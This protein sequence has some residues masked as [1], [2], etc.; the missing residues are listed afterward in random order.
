MTS[1]VLV[2]GAS[3][4][5][6][7]QLV[8]ALLRRGT[9][10]LAAT[11]GT[12][13]PARLQGLDGPLEVAQW[14]PRAPAALLARGA[15][16]V[17]HAAACYGRAGEAPTELVEANVLAGLRL[18]QAAPAAGIRAFLHIGT[19]LPPVVSAYARSKRQFAEW[20]AGLASALPVVELR[21]EHFF[22]GGDDPSKFTTH[23][24]R[25]C[26]AHQPRLALTAGTQLRD[27]IHVDD[28]VSAILAVLDRGVPSTG[29]ACY[30][31][32]SGE[33]VPVRAVVELIHRLSGSRTQLDFGALPARLGEPPE[34]RADVAAL[35]LLGWAPTL[36]LA[37]GIAR[38]IDDERLR[39]AS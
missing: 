39:C 13:I 3:G 18:L 28:A 36:P 38:F 9:A 12:G 20:A 31:I 37:A 25:A 16:L 6:G 29:H 11:R 23:V 17:V 8:R 27:F 4:F 35:H 19:G 32:G 10:V 1:R 14:E 15:D 22:G 30:G 26:L 34:C 5:L 33:A 24:A 21:C 2:T 7:A